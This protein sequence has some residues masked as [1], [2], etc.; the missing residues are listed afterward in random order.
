MDK[1][2]LISVG[3]EYGSAGHEIARKIAEMLGINLYDR[4]MLDSIAKEKG[5]DVEELSKYEEKPRSAFFSRR[6]GEHS[7]STADI[8]ADMQFE[9]IKK[10]ADE[11]ESFVIVGRCA[12]HVLKEYKNHIS[13]FILGDEDTEIE[14]IMNIF[15]LSKDDALA[16]IKKHNKT[17]KAYHNNHCE[18]KW[19]DSRSYDLCI[20]SSKL[21]V[22]KTA[23]CLVRY[24]SD[25]IEKF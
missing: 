13:I 6:V 18:M 20:N 12:D 5:F 11:G 17:R 2:V 23:E 3:R 1:Q 25:R 14:R 15:N 21:G 4:S 16:K 7:N 24:I 8:L 9:F 19:G 10:K 22:E